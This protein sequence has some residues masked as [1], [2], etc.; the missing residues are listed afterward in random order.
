M[1]TT[2]KIRFKWFLI[3]LILLYSAPYW[4]GTISSLAIIEEFCTSDPSDCHKFWNSIWVDVFRI[5]IFL[6]TIYLIVKNSRHWK[7]G[8][9]FHF[10]IAVIYA[11]IF[12]IIFMLLHPH[13][14]QEFQRYV[15]SN[16]IYFIRFEDFWYSLHRISYEFLNPL[17]LFLTLLIAYPLQK[18][19]HSK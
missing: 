5:M 17:Y 19:G 9:L 14:I 1:K 12:D 16:F 11:F 7:A 4:A 2:H 15:V 6:L 3:A 13:P 8:V 18:W 10:F